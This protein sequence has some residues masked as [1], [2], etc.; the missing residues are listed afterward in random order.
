VAEIAVGA[1]VVA[2]DVVVMVAVVRMRG[3]VR[4]RR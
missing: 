4:V 3:G 1:V 2:V